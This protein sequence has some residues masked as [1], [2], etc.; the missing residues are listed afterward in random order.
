MYLRRR[1]SYRCREVFMSAIFLVLGLLYIKQGNKEK[2]K[3]MMIT[4]FVFSTLFLISYIIY[5]SFHGDTKFAGE[6]FIR[7]IYFLILISHIVLS[8]V[9]LPFVLITFYYSLYG[10]FPSHKKIA[11]YTFPM[12]LYVSVTGVLVYIFIQLTSV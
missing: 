11:R 5:H 8:V 10:N 9:A 6:G 2:H 3:R 1:N 7:I 12:W 4:A